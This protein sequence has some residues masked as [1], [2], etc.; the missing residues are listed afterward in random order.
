MTLGLGVLEL[1]A[2]LTA[3]D[4]LVFWT[5][6]TPAWLRNTAATRMREVMD[7][8]TETRPALAYMFRWKAGVSTGPG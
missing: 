5:G 6:F 1:C 7:M 2:G 4:W 3:R 8:M